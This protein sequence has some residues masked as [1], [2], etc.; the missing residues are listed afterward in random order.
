M[1]RF[2]WAN[3]TGDYDPSTGRFDGAIGYLMDGKAEIFMRPTEYGTIDN[4]FVN[5]LSL[6]VWSGKP[7]QP[8]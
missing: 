5:Y 1:C 4:K 3:E 2:V 6:P 8:N 7:N